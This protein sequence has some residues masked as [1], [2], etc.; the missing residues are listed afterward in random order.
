MSKIVLPIACRVDGTSL[1]D[2]RSLLSELQAVNPVDDGLG[3]EL[4][5]NG[6][7]DT[8]TVWTKGLDWTI[9]GGALR[10][11][12]GIANSGTSEPITLVG[13]LTYRVVFNASAL[14]GGPIRAQFTGGIQAN[15]TLRTLPGLYSEDI[16]AGVGNL[17]LEF[18]GASG[19]MPVIEYVSVREVL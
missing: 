7:F 16:V 4:T 19:A 8:D 3:P 6:S 10:K 1:S 9:S 14:S 11:D 13:G 18:F 5:T 12:P 2:G 17:L 15:G